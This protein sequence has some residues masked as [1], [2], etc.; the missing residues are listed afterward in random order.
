MRGVSAART[1][2]SDVPQGAHMTPPPIAE[3]RLRRVLSRLLAPSL[4]EEV[5]AL[6]REA[7]PEP[8]RPPRRTAE[9]RRRA[10]LLCRRQGVGMLAREEGA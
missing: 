8:D 2:P 7:R 10:E 5:I 1:Q 6:C 4:V 3:A 9:A